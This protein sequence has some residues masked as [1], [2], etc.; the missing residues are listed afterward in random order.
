[1]NMDLSGKVAIVTGGGSGIGHGIGRMFTQL[2][3]AV[4]VA[5]VELCNAE[6]V[7]S[8]LE[9]VG[10]QGRSIR[11]TSRTGSSTCPG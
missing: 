8:E 6:A 10:G 4:A 1:M 11:L 3:A 5:D 9:A 7:A 2:G